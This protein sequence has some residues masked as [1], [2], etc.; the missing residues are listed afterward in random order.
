MTE[1]LK[2]QIKTITSEFELI[3]DE[4]KKELHILS[5]FISERIKSKTD[6]IFICVHNSRRSHLS[7]I[8]AQVA[9]HHYG[10]S[11]VTTY[12]GGTEVTCMFPKISQTLKSQGFEINVIAETANPIYAIKYH[13]NE[14]AI[15]G[16]SKLFDD[17]FNPQENFG[18][19]MVC[20]SA[21]T[22]CPFIATAA[23]R[24]LL[25]FSDPKE[26]D[27]TALQTEKYIERSHQIAREL[28]YAF[29]MI[30]R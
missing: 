22:N 16:Y 19:I 27:G 10:F 30:E 25:P 6:L 24:I 11:N 18:A 4:R 3:S 17:S 8:W 2:E 13:K 23:Q 26:F 7:Q 5:L 1:I 9:A 14:P 15:I 29:S 28:F 20:S 12:S 21:D